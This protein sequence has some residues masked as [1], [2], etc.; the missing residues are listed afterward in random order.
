M[1]CFVLASKSN[2]FISG[3]VAVVSTCSASAPL[4]V[5]AYIA[6]AG[7]QIVSL[8]AIFKAEPSPCKTPVPFGTRLR[9]TLVSP[10]AVI[11]GALPVDALANV[12]SLTADPVAVKIANSLPL[13]SKIEVP[14]LGPVS[15][16]HLTLPTSDLV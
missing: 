10:E 2:T 16:T 7:T 13:V 5:G 3:L 11:V 8:P 12:I 1:Y 4:V 6:A 14:I 15:Y 9:L